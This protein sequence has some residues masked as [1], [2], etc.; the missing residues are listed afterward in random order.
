[1]TVPAHTSANLTAHLTGTGIL[2]ILGTAH[3]LLAALLWRRRQDN[4]AT[5]DTPLRKATSR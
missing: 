1:M 5:T 4:P 2:A 3:V